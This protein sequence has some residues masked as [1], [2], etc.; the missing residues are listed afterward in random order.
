M[1]TIG[2]FAI[3]A[4]ILLVSKEFWIRIL[5]AIMIVIWGYTLA[6]TNLENRRGE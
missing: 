2:W 3:P 1:M 6:K 5:T 4:L